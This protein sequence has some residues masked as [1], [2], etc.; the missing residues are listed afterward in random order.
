[1]AVGAP[2]NR[3]ISPLRPTHEDDIVPPLAGCP[4]WDHQ[5]RITG[6]REWRGE[7]GLGLWEEQSLNPYVGKQIP[8]RKFMGP[9]QSPSSPE[10]TTAEL[11]EGRQS[12]PTH[13]PEPDSG[14]DYGEGLKLARKPTSA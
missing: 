4:G 13:P 3:L 2:L 14:V 9:L 6:S 11:P 1:M 8:T 5:G 10:S 12:Q 7:Q